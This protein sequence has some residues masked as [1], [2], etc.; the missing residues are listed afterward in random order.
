MP[1]DDVGWE[2]QITPRTSSHLTYGMGWCGLCGW[3]RDGF[4]GHHERSVMCRLMMRVGNVRLRLVPRL[5]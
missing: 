1:F 5:I 4:V 3:F 2:C